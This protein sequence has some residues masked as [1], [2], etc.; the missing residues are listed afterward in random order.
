[1]SIRR[2]SLAAAGTAAALMIASAPA[3]AT[4]SYVTTSGAAPTAV[5]GGV[6]AIYPAPRQVQPR[7]G[8]ITL[9]GTVGEVTGAGTDAPA[10]REVNAVLTAAGVKHIVTGTAAAVTVYVGG[11]SENPASAAVLA[12]LNAAGPGG[13]A[14]GGYALAAG[15]ES[16]HDVIVASGVD[17][18]GTFYAAQTLRQLVQG[19]Q[20]GDV[21]VRDWPS[22]PVRGVIEGFYGA[23]WSTADRIS[24]FVFDGQNKMNTYVYSPKDDPYLRAQWRDPYPPAQ[25]AVIRQLAGAAD[26]SHVTFTYAL[27]PGL[28]VCFSSAS[29]IQALVAKFQSLWDTGVRAFAI[30][31]DDVSEKSWNCAADQSAFGSPSPA[32]VAAAQVHVLN[33]VQSEFIAAHPGAAP[34][35]FVPTEYSDTT[36][37]PYKQ[38]IASSLDPKVVVEWTGD[39]VVTGSITSAQA[40]AAR[41][42]FGHD[43]LVWD[44]YP[45]ND[46]TSDLRLLMGPYTGRAADLGSYVTGI[47]AN[48]M[49]EEE[50]SKVALFTA[51]SYFWN[52]SS[53][54][55]QSAWLAGLKA[56]GGPAWPAL[57][58]LAENSYSSALNPGESPA[59]TPL[60]TDFWNAWGSGTPA[61]LSRASGALLAYFAAMAAAPAQ[62]RAGLGNPDFLSE[63]SPWLDKLGG[64]GQAGTTA[65]KLL[66]AERAGQ[67]AA[68]LADR[69]SLEA[70]QATLASVPQQV[71]PGLMDPFLAKAVA[72][73][74]SA[75]LA[76]AASPSVVLPGTPLKVTETYTNTT[77]GTQNG[78]TLSVP[79]QSG[80]TV[81]PGTP[82]SFP[83]VPPGGKITATWTA[84]PPSSP[85]SG[86]AR[87]LGWARFTPSGSSGGARAVL[88]TA[89]AKVPYAS[90]LLT[91][92]PASTWLAPGASTAATVTLVNRSSSPLTANWQAALPAGVTASVA[93]GTLTAPAAGTA[94]AAV[95]LSAASGTAANLSGEVS[96]T[97]TSGAGPVASVAQPV[98]V[99]PAK[100]GAGTEYVAGYTSSD[101]TPVNL[102][103]GTA[104]SPIATGAQPGDVVASPDGSTLYTANQSANTISVIDTAAGAVRATWKTGS[105]PAALALSA[106]GSTLWVSDYSDNAVQSVDTATGTVSAEIPVGKGPQNLALTPDG[107][108]LLVAAQNDNALVPLDVATR[109]AGTPIPAGNGPF[110]VAVT[111]DGKTAYVGDQNAS[112]VTPVDLATGTAG[113]AITLH[114]SGPFGIALTPDGTT[115]YVTDSNASVVDVIDVATGTVEPPLSVGS[116]PTWVTFSPTGDTAYICVTGNNTLL[117]VDITSGQPG[118]AVP[119]GQFPIASVTVAG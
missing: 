68:A 63:I 52:T 75:A 74:A 62:L 66:L 27:S 82:V 111:P 95:T 53:Y 118:T 96:F 90:R 77:T 57:K 30:P 29:D 92:T 15:Q 109:T 72:A 79:S 85:P 119:V 64:Y 12:G 55:P 58:V 33:A 67:G 42:V 36:A 84:T 11:P 83:A 2:L 116:G 65:V 81:T 105:V 113:P 89:Y 88:G 4:T 102:S 108:T 54:D 47:T 16:G 73:S 114:G 70:G 21:L 86:K 103:A 17:G 99:S 9:P 101:V 43:I 7:A 34:L 23:P 14:P 78:L 19:R 25:L 50:A 5:S 31:F 32:D 59:L 71:A 45:V 76:L 56:I 48:P 69:S 61:S 8:T 20:V 51:A 98:F 40:S 10:L 112:A 104:G 24:S 13:L 93:S 18:T 49:I 6:P 107:T 110:D 37:T 91:V 22:M 26:A 87:L 100:P 46:Y 1:M 38:V 44:N 97:A 35:E 3:T 117:P 80:F 60:I 39:G 115:L 41:S 106:D 94:A 28:S